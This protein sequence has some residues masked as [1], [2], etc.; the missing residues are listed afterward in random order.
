MQFLGYLVLLGYAAITLNL[1][2]FQSAAL[3]LNTGI[4]DVV[5]L[6]GAYALL[7][8][9]FI[10]AILCVVAVRRSRFAVASFTALLAWS[11]IVRWLTRIDGVLSAL[12]FDYSHLDTLMIVV[13][14]V[15]TAWLLARGKM[16]Q[17]RALR[18]LG[19]TILTALLH[20]TG[21][22]DNPFSPLFSAGGVLLIVIGIVWSVLTAGGR[23]LNAD[24]AGFPRISRALMYFGYVM[25]SLSVAHWFVVSH[26]VQQQAVQG[27]IALSGFALYGL[28]LLMWL[29]VMRGRPLLHEE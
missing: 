29:L 11:A 27:D 6:Y 22:L 2:T 25:L 18:L 9:A 8:L 20:Q 16:T 26:D 4:N 5:A 1:E 19:I 28:T 14:I 21:F 24:S 3:N 17:E 13:L 10:C 12:H 15:M 23:F 7:L